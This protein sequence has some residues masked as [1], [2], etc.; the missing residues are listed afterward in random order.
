MRIGSDTTVASTFTTESAVECGF[1]AAGA[2]HIQSILTYLYRDA[3]MAVLREYA[4]NAVDS[5][6]RAGVTAP[7]EVSLPSEWDP[8]LTVVDHG[9]GLDEQGIVEVYAPYGTSTKRDADDQVGAFGVGAKAAFGVATQFTVTGVR[10]GKRVSA[11]FALNKAGVATVE[12]IGREATD[13]PNGVTVV[14][15]VPDAAAMRQAAEKLFAYWKPG[16]VLVD[17]QEPVYLPDTMLPI[18]DGVFADRQGVAVDARQG[19]LVR[20]DSQTGVTVVMGGIPY[21]ASVAMLRAVARRIT[22]HRAARALALALCAK[23]TPTRLV[24]IAAIGEV[25]ITPSREDL[26]DTPRTL[27]VLVRLLTSFEDSVVSAV[28]TALEAEP[29]AMHASTR[30]ATLGP[31][32]PTGA[33]TGGELRWREQ[34]LPYRVRLPFPVIVRSTTGRSSRCSLTE[35]G[36]DH[37][38]L[39]LGT[40]YTNIRV[41]TGVDTDR[42]RTVRRLANRFMTRHDL[43]RLI[44]VPTPAT[45]VEWFAADPAD[46]NSALAAVTFEEFHSQARA[47]PTLS[48]GRLDPQ[49]MVSRG[50]LGRSSTPWTVTRMAAQSGRV[51]L[52]ERLYTDQER[53]VVNDILT[54]RDL[55]VEL[56]GHQTADAFFRRFP[57]ATRLASVAR[58]HARTLMDTASEVESL[59]L[60][61]QQDNALAVIQ[62]VS[63]L[64]RVEPLRQMVSDYVAAYRANRATTG[65]RRTLL[66]GA[67]RLLET[68]PAPLKQSSGLPLLDMVLE[69]VRKS[70]MTALDEGLVTDL[71]AYLTTTQSSV[72][73]A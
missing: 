28:Q 15:P 48:T 24:Y 1:D 71:V 18:T 73:S 46:E 6:V 67:H 10:D 56:T 32:L 40:D 59:A 33:L 23:S 27:D 62:N 19:H 47:L 53:A 7:V 60:R 51:L 9:V 25:D 36:S 20:E 66:L 2:A 65:D 4:A 37:A 17:G 26:R 58:E 13:A 54:E 52:A 14:V 31:F 5:H 16:T 22:E 30:L 45:Q 55:V 68:W 38:S 29:S 49:Y 50:S 35:P 3:A 69:T 64:R 42:E 21:A 72:P 41:V 34:L 11:L 43:S 8:S 63:R 57:A 44:L 70:R 61:Y 12:I 39:V